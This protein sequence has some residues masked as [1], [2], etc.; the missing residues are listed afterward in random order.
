MSE[1][2]AIANWLHVAGRVTPILPYYAE[3]GVDIANFDYVVSSDE[4]SNQ[5]PVTCC[6]GN[7]KSLLFVE[8]ESRGNP[9]GSQQP[10]ARVP[11]PARFYP[12]IGLRDSAEAKPENV[13][14]L[15]KTFFERRGAIA[16]RSSP[17]LTSE[18]AGKS[19]FRQA[20]PCCQ[21]LQ[22]AGILDSCRLPGDGSCGL[23]LVQIEAGEVGPPTKNEHL[24][25]PPEQLTQNLRLACQLIPEDDLHLRIINTVS[26]F[27]WRDLTPDCLPCG[28]SHPPPSAARPP[29]DNAYGLAIDLGTTQI[30]LSLRDLKHGQRLYAR[31]GPNPQSL[32]GADVVTRLIAAGESPENARRLGRMP[33]EA[34]ADTLHEMG[35]RNGFRRG[36]LSRLSSLE[37]PRCYPY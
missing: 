7:I 6:N 13:A 28:P 24:L 17:S 36:M 11:R 3:A 19:H 26:K 20:H 32:Y 34:V 10:F 2:G 5:L 8:G 23:C 1:A 14:A 31:V 22:G 30:S 9:G 4:A 12:L 16:C 29:A 27:A 21:I 37:T 33:L 15:V 18:A 35:L 25:L